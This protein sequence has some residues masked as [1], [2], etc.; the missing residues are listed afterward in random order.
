MDALVPKLTHF[1]ES[2]GIPVSFRTLQAAD[3]FL[4]GVC[5][6]RGGLVVDRDG[7][8]YPGDLLHEA[9]HIAVVPGADRATLNGPAIADRPD[10]GAEEMMAM[11][12]SYAAAH[13]MGL[14]PTVVFHANG[15]NGGGENLLESFS[16]PQPIGVPMLHFTG[17]CQSPAI[18]AEDGAAP[19]PA[20]RRWLRA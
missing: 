14:E 19:F 17:M 8:L 7:L 12:W 10:R 9:G 5:I 18:P 6:E 2:I 13:H 15:Y 20:M 1:I 3:C 16:S 4:P 11:A